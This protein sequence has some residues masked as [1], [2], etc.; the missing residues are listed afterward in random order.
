LQNDAVKKPQPRRRVPAWTSLVGLCVFVLVLFWMHRLLGEYRWHDILASMRGIPRES[1][2]RAAALAAAGYGCLSLY[3]ILGV[4]FAGAILPIGRMISI[5]LM[6]YGI[7]HTFGT[8]TLSGGAIRY[9][10][11]SL[12]GL[13]AKQIATVIAFGTL[14]FGLGAA[15]LLGVSL[16]A[17]SEL[18]AA[19]LH[20][21]VLLVRALGVA[22]LG[23]ACA[24]LSFVLWRREPVCIRGVK[25]RVPR[26]RIA[27][28][29]VV[30]ACADLL[31]AAGV[32]YVLLPSQ[33]QIGFIS[34]AGIYLLGIAA[35]IISTVPGGVG[36]FESVMLLLLSAAPRDR[37]LGALLAYRA[38][39]YLA[40]F[41]LAL[42]LLA[43]HELWVQRGPFL[44]IAQ[45]A[46]T[47]LAA[48]APQ[49][50]AIAVFGAGA[51]LVFSGATPGF[52]HRLA[53]LH[54]LVPL[55][56]LELSHL[57][58]SVVGVG[59]LV[60]A[61]GLYRR[62][63]AAWWLTLWLLLAGAISSLLKGFDY[64]EALALTAVAGLLIASRGRFARR[65]SLIEQR[66]STPWLIALALVLGAA[67][68]LVG[69]AYRH[70]P[71]ANELWWQFAFE[72]P[73]PRSL[74]A[75][76]L[77]L[78]IAASYGLW[79]LLRPAPPALVRPSVVD[80][81]S[82]TAV[83]ARNEDTTANLALLG[84][85]NLLFNEERTAFIMY[86][87]SGHSWVSMGDPVGPPAECEALAWQFLERCDVMAASPVFYQVAPDNLPLYVDLGL[88]LTKLGE[89]ARVALP[90]FSLDGGDRADLRQAHRRAARDGARFEVL[91]RRDV[92]ALVPQ[93]RC[94]SDAW[95]LD[96]AGG[97][98]GFSLGYFDAR[99][100][101]NF[102]CALVRNG[103]RIV[104]FA[105]LWTA[106]TAEIS[107]DLMRYG[108]GAPKGVI[109]YLLIECMLW[110]RAQGYKWFNLGM[111]PL[112]GLEEHPL[113][114]A[115]H[116]LG[117]LVQRYGENFYHFEGLRK[118]KEKF[119]PV[120]RGRYL[121]A[122]GGLSLAG[123]LV[124][125]TTLISGGGAGRKG[126][127]LK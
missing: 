60:L 91:H 110:G 100:L 103:E 90:A 92:A 124:D 58:G 29:Q 59:L 12:L 74:R 57:L 96:K 64:E 32:L 43:W 125:V 16:L 56:V 7:G 45:L 61:N 19:I 27:L 114:P 39:Y 34:F 50:I 98:K 73:A 68:L 44:R 112:S 99:Y 30:V 42:T 123:A 55:P 71:Y 4:T 79:R 127:D 89:E 24:Y 119:L 6:A 121:A 93:L 109:D 69:F 35:G 37:L 102:D 80:L 10:A 77:A 38:I 22:L 41:A 20:L 97:E 81:D 46:R 83:I 86:Q 108:E 51:V 113:A 15:V 88:N 53:L 115:W 33:A 52:T 72:A 78:I 5:S 87:V 105:N 2:L 40:P 14:T 116:K 63:D 36:V 84:D 67:T 85:K 9:R 21:P 101:A 126:R 3:E 107:V 8:S 117:R 48:V 70:I 120:W 94:I 95:L 54:D 104:A 31:C 17:K 47:W 18:S 66:Y 122:P 76:L 75:L 13:R 25:L 1:L 82:A 65:A 111:A 49:A 118:F 11:Y 28:A 23:A 106:G 62:L 26:P